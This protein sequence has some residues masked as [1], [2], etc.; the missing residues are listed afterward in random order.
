M[1]AYTIH[2][3]AYYTANLMSCGLV[4]ESTRKQG[5]V[6]LR[7]DHVQFGEYV[8]AL[9]TAI[10]DSEADALCRALLN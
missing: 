6:V 7:H 10:D 2:Q 4:I 9:R 8:D 3:S 5:G 1:S